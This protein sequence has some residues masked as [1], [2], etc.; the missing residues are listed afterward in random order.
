MQI[1][2]DRALFVKISALVFCSISA[3]VYVWYY[4]KSTLW[5]CQGARYNEGHLIC[6]TTPEGTTLTWIVQ[7]FLSVCV[8][9]FVVPVV[10]VLAINVQHDRALRQPAGFEE[11]QRVWIEAG[12]GHGE[13]NMY[14]AGRA[15]GLLTTLYLEAV[16]VASNWV[17]GPFN[18]L[19]PR[20]GNGYGN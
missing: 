8:A 6:P 12:V 16:D 20:D 18:R 15:N 13:G 5:L 7:N 2:E 10:F 9:S 11:N 14:R 3:L 4:V 1:F 19:R 17:D